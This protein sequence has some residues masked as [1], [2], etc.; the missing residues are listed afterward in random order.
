MLTTKRITTIANNISG[1]VKQPFHESGIL[2]ADELRAVNCQEDFNRL[3]AIF[4]LVR[5]NKN[6]PFRDLKGW[7]KIELDKE[8]FEKLSAKF[9]IDQA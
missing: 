8:D 6:T 7:L 2:I 1:L 9:K 5:I 4:G 3:Q